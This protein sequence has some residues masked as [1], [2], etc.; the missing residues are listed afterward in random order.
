MEFEIRMTLI[1][2]CEELIEFQGMEMENNF[3]ILR[4]HLNMEN[5]YPTCYRA[6]KTNPRSVQSKERKNHVCI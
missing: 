5:K 6:I 1:S 2:F 3:S 4:I